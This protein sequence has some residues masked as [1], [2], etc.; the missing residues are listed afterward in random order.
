MVLVSYVTMLLLVLLYQAKYRVRFGVLSSE[1]ISDRILVHNPNYGDKLGK[2]SSRDINKLN[3]SKEFINKLEKSVLSEGF[4][5]P[6]LCFS[7]EE[8]LFCQFGANRLFVAK[9]NKLDVPVIIVDY[10]NKYS[11]LVSLNV[12]EVTNKYD[13]GHIINMT[14]ELLEVRLSS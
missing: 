8:G 6:L 2:Y 4:R 5:N 10:V 11:H 12:H 9:K 7:I 3:S 1:S 13:K 14:D